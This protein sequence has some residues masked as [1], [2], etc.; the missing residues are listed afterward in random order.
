MIKFLLACLAVA[1]TLLCFGL[2]GLVCWGFLTL[3]EATLLTFPLVGGVLAIIVFFG[4][5]GWIL[6]LGLRVIWIFVTSFYETF[7]EKFIK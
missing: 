1:C 3:V 7:C 6:C 5:I 4:W 2:V